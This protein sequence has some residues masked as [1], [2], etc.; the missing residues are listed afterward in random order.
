MALR[1]VK[2][3]RKNKRQ[4]RGKHYLIMKVHNVLNHRFVFGKLLYATFQ[5]LLRAMNRVASSR[6]AMEIMLT[7]PVCFPKVPSIKFS[8]SLLPYPMREHLQQMK[9]PLN[10][11][12]FATVVS[13]ITDVAQGLTTVSCVRSM[14]PFHYCVYSIVL[15]INVFPF[16][17]E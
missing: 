16:P 8:S 3:R 2:S 1:K 15:A 7:F 11:L 13:P 10:K 17:T 5:F 12:S 4:N 9:D 14:Q 6:V